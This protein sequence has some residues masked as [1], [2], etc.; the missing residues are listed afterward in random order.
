MVPLFLFSKVDNYLY[1]EYMKTL[2]DKLKVNYGEVF[3]VVGYDERF[4]LDAIVRKDGTI[5]EEV[6]LRLRWHK[7]SDQHGEWEAEGFDRD[8][9]WRKKLRE[10]NLEII[11]YKYLP[12]GRNTYWYAFNQ[13]DGQTKVTK[14]YWLGRNADYSRFVLGNCFA[15]KEDAEKYGGHCLEL[16]K[17]RYNQ[18]REEQEK[19]IFS[20]Y[21]ENTE[22]PKDMAKIGE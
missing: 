4:K 10:E 1:N 3:E 7:Y 13:S 22:H 8:D 17:E 6:L 12:D 19:M 21:R 11:R 9:D 18:I 16:M 20:K 5:M 2:Q 15:T 14:A